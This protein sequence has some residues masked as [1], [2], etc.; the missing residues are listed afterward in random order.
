[1]SLTISNQEIENE[2]ESMPESDPDDELS[3]R[4]TGNGT[5]L[6]TCKLNTSSNK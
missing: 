5:V 6:N 2:I 3:T 4:Y 1:M